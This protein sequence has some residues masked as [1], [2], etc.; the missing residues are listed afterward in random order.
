[1]L[2]IVLAIILY[3]FNYKI[4]ESYALFKQENVYHYLCKHGYF[5]VLNFIWK[6]T[7]YVDAFVIFYVPIKIAVIV[8]GMIL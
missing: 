7:K 5:E 2:D 1:M 4:K 6:L 3:W 8:V